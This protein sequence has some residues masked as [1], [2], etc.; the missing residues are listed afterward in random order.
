MGTI[1]I[2]YGWLISALFIKIK[3]TVEEVLDGNKISYNYG[4]QI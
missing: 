1:R 2:K 3:E 4:I